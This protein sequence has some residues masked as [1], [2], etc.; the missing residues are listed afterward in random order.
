V[1]TQPHTQLFV[2]TLVRPALPAISLAR[3]Q[4]SPALSHLFGIST[5]TALIFPIS[6]HNNHPPF[7]IFDNEYTPWTRHTDTH[8][9]LLAVPPLP[10][11]LL[12]V[13]AVSVFSFDL[14]ASS[15]V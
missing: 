3:S 11:Q 10:F 13:T 2:E 5:T 15:G 4:T 9:A 1:T 7:L 8:N 12:Q 14:L 6:I